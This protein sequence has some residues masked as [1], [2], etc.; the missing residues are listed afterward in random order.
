VDILDTSGDMQFPAMRRL[1]IA[2]AH[3]FMLVYAATS[4]PSFQ[5][6]KQCFEE[7]REQRGDFQV[8]Y[9]CSCSPHFALSTPAFCM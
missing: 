3:A 9:R 4:A 8:S 1:S 6:V 2:T 7:I 5:C